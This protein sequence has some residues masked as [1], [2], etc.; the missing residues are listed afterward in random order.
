MVLAAHF[1]LDVLQRFSQIVGPIWWNEK[2]DVAALYFVR[3]ISI[4]FFCRFVPR[5]YGPVQRL[6]IDRILCRLHNGSQSMNGHISRFLFAHPPPRPKGA[7]S[8]NFPTMLAERKGA[9]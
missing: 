5:L 3:S 1:M 8:G 6:R 7:Q 2:R 4:Q 9:E